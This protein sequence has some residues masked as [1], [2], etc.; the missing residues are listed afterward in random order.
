M[1]TKTLL[2]SWFTVTVFPFQLIGPRLYVLH[3]D[4]LGPVYL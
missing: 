4:P 3:L 2:L 1:L